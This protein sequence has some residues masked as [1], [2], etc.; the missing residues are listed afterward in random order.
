MLPAAAARGPGI[1]VTPKMAGLRP[2]L[3]LLSGSRSSRPIA[4]GLRHLARSLAAQ[5]AID[6]PEVSYPSD[7]TALIGETQWHKELVNG[8]TLIG[9]L[10]GQLELRVFNNGKK[11]ATG[12]LAVRQGKDGPSEWF[13][14]DVWDNLGEA[15][16]KQLTKGTQVHV[17]GRLRTNEYENNEGRKITYSSIAVNQINRVDP[18]PGA[19]DQP[20]Y[21][22]DT[23]EQP[24]A[25]WNQSQEHAQDVQPSTP[26]Q[27]GTG[28][29]Q[30]AGADTPQLSVEQRWN[31]VFANYSQYWDN[32]ANKRNP[33]A[34]DFKHK[35]TGA[36]LWIDS[37]DTP[38]FVEQQLT[39]L[40]PPPAPFGGV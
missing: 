9:R 7:Q 35:S 11:K 32:R 27:P 30:P 3:H 10:G 19:Y 1:L 6:A 8:I 29:A 37:R 28:F 15:A 36:P 5:T 25:P 13:T 12:R 24:Q 16:A 23:Q 21:A 2:A 38:I 14:I 17:T 31:D 26:L 39:T 18:G 4:P 34:P 20:Q 33:R 40:P 22:Q